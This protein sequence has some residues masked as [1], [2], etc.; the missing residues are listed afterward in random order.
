MI[1]ILDIEYNTTIHS[2]LT[3]DFNHS[4]LVF[5]YIKL[6]YKFIIILCKM[7]IIS[8]NTRPPSK[9]IIIIT[10]VTMLHIN[11]DEEATGPFVGTPNI[12]SSGV[13]VV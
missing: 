6:S 9:I 11:T 7:Y 13:F 10:I 12:T 2:N 4:R 1:H 5:M 3:I 8:Y